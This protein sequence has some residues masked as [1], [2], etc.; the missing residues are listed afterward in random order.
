M[1]EA[2]AMMVRARIY[3]FIEMISEK[4]AG[5]V[6]GVGGEADDRRWLRRAI[7]AS[8]GDDIAGFSKTAR[9][10]DSISWIRTLPCDGIN[11]DLRNE[12]SGLEAFW[13]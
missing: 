7:Q 11:A 8:N 4:M 12:T 3:R 6:A 13:W 2:A 10:D 1:V 9:V 5:D